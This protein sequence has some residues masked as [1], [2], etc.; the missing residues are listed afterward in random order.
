MTTQFQPERATIV[1]DDGTAIGYHSFGEGPGVIVVGGVLSTGLDY[2]D[3]ALTLS[4]CYT[5]HLIDRRGRGLSGPQA[6]D[7]SLD[8]ECN[9]LLAVVAATNA[10]IVFGHSFGG[11]VALETARRSTA[12][13]HVVV[14]E[15]GVPLS[16]GL[17]L[18]WLDDYEQHLVDDDRRGAFACM[19]TGAGF[20]PA[21]LTKLP[22]WY[23]RAVLR[24]AVRG[25][26]WETME[27]LLRSNLVE[28]RILQTITTST[29]ARFEDI[30][31]PVALLGGERSPGFVRDILNTL[32]TNI[33]S[34]ELELLPGLDHAAPQ[35]KPRAV[36]AAIR[37]HLH[38]ADL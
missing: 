8:D 12:F 33:R 13:D 11:L 32:H 9:D 2:R 21:T 26:H 17:R 20:A 1:T 19:V 30:T 34:S 3:L 36:G 27:P 6:E 24:L 14:Y 4:G 23:V 28:H 37:R 38:V 7:H 29:A 18:G 10:K 31:D 5:V 22:Q 25:S 15:P 16:G 35:R